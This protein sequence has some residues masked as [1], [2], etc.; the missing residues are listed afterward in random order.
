MTWHS[1]M[2]NILV[3]E[4]AIQKLTEELESTKISFEEELANRD[5]IIAELQENSADL[6][7]TFNIFRNETFERCKSEPSYLDIMAPKIK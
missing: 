6:D 5:A 2:K 4:N 1:K 3:V 7:S